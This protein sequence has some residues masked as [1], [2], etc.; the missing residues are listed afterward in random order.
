MSQNS[1][2]AAAIYLATEKLKDVDFLIKITLLKD[3][4]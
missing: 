1:G 2:L 4:K 3:T